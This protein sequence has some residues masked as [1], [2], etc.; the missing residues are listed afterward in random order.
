MILGQPSNDRYDSRPGRDV[1]VNAPGAEP[2][3]CSAEITGF[4]ASGAL[5]FAA[6][7]GIASCLRTAV[8][9]RQSGNQLEILENS[10]GLGQLCNSRLI[11]RERQSEGELQ[12]FFGAGF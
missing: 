3:L 1:T 5:E 8:N 10:I 7:T 4:A 2:V 12:D 9:I 11:H 6:G